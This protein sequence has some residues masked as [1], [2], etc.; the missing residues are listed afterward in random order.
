MDDQR[1]HRRI[2]ADCSVET[3]LEDE[4]VVWKPAVLIDCATGGL[5]L[6]TNSE[7]KAGDRVRIRVADSRMGKDPI[8]LGV[9]E[10]VRVQHDKGFRTP[11]A[12]RVGLKFTA[13]DAEAVQRLYHAAQIQQ[14]VRKRAAL[15]SGASAKGKH[16]WV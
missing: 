6:R 3:A 7:M 10:V 5:G 15:R 11:F 9:A 2:E 1:Q 12:H 16:V 4:A 13:P 8:F 14:T